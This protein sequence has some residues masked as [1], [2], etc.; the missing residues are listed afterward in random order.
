MV[1]GRVEDAA[2][3]DGQGPQAQ[4][5]RQAG[6]PGHGSE[7]LQGHVEAADPDGGYPTPVR[8]SPRAG[9]RRLG[10]RQRRQAPERRLGGRGR[11]QAA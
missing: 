9:G 2:G 4:A 10:A 8:Q 5:G 1:A 7:A 6:G 3:H 11:S